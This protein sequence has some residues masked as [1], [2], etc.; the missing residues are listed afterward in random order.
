MIEKTVTLDGTNGIGI[1]EQIEA[2]KE[3]PE[4]IDFDKDIDS[5]V[6]EARVN[7]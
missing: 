1:S 2:L 7:L 6:I 4:E 5:V 3:N